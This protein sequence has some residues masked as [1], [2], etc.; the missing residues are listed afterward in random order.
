MASA[1]R[2][3][4]ASYWREVVDRQSESGLSAASFCRQES[5]SAA[6]FYAW[7]R[8]FQ[9]QESEFPQAAGRDDETSLRSQLL[10]VR[11]EPERSSSPVRIVLPQ[12]ASIEAPGGI[13]R[14]ALV[15]LLGAL[16]EAQRC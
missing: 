4:R 11:I 6:S 7:R 15:E 10:P 9:E 3:D 13:D 8:K 1:G 12:G 14:G 2:S 16:R 5:L